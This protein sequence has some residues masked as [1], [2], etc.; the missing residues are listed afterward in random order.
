MPLWT[1]EQYTFSFARLGLSEL[2]GASSTTHPP[3]YPLL[4]HVVLWLLS[5]PWSVRVPAFIGGLAG[6]VVAFRGAHALGFRSAAPFCALVVSA[7]VYHVYFS[8]EARGYSWFATSVGAA[9]FLAIRY[10]RTLRPGDLAWSLACIGFACSMHFLALPS[11][12]ML[13]VFLLAVSARRVP[14]SLRVSRRTAGWT[15]VVWALYLGVMLLGCLLIRERLATLVKSA[16]FS[17]TTRVDVSLALVA[18]I[19]GRWSGLGFGAGPIVGGLALVGWGVT[20]ARSRL[21]GCLVGTVTAAPLLTLLFVPWPTFFEGR[22]LMGSL[23]LALVLGAIGAWS[24]PG[25][26]A[27]ALPQTS[28]A[29]R[30]VRVGRGLLA[31]AILLCQLNVTRQQL[32]TPRK[33]APVNNDLLAGDAFGW[34]HV[35]LHSYLDPWLIKS[36]TTED[37]ATTPAR[38]GPLVLPLP[39]WR[40]NEVEVGGES[41]WK[42]VNPRADDSFVVVLNTLPAER[43]NGVDFDFAPP[44]STTREGLRATVSTLEHPHVERPISRLLLLGELPGRNLSFRVNMRSA[45]I[46][47]ASALLERVADTMVYAEFDAPR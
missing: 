2:L 15:L 30:S 12:A 10:A 23:L 33:H 22:Y 24:L 19:A 35:V 29:L 18:N 8:Q 5:P 36:V 13:T 11:A 14:R 37:F 17:A 7:S 42:F 40:W 38:I 1:D 4:A 34:R 44:T 31:L 43:P 47:A 41:G 9:T 32:S 21:A 45:R 20:F 27:K 6:V 3:G 26:L 46:E 39:R 16:P 25:L 28:R